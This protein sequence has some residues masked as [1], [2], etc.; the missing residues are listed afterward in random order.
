M[1]NILIVDDE[2]PARERLRR[3]LDDLDNVTIVAEAENGVQAIRAFEDNNADVVLLDIR[4][5]LMDGM[6]TARHL[7]A[8][9][10]PPAI[11]F[12]TAYGEHALQAFET[13][14]VDYLVKP[15]RSERLKDA[16]SSAQRLNRAQLDQVSSDFTESNARTHICVRKGNTLEL[17]PV[18]DIYYFMAD[19]KYVSIVHKNGE[20][21]LDE[22]LINLEEEFQE[23]FFRVHRNALVA[24]NQISGLSKE[25][26]STHKVILKDN[27]ASIEVSRRHLPAVR[28]L[29]RSKT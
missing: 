6:E 3:L 18:E 15:I 24:V 26:D 11:I 7:M 19:N 20:A 17:V 8:N 14:A 5:P 21:L 13:H 25:A 10:Q 4:M 12:T 27:D 23:S 22:A 9:E 1:M 16:L 29:V 2:K 28:K